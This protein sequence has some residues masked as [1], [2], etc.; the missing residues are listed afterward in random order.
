MKTLAALVVAGLL[1][2]GCGSGGSSDSA[3]AQ[4]DIPWDEVNWEQID[5]GVKPIEWCLEKDVYGNYWK[6]VCK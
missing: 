6:V 5:D 2:V 1:M 3:T 4:A